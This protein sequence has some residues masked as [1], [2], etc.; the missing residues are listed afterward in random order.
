MN[1]NYLINGKESVALDPFDRGLAFGDGIF[2]TFKV[3]DGNPLHWDYHF[4]KLLHDANFLGIDPPKKELLLNDIKILFEPSGIFIAKFII[5][6]GSS[7]RGY[8]PPLNIE[9][10]RI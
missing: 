9:P 1:D 3:S 8:S 7:N 5:T 4:N 10:N 2:R 6:R